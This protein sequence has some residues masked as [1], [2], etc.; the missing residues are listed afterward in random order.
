MNAVLTSTDWMPSGRLVNAYWTET[1]CEFLRLLRTPAL[2]IPF[3]IIPL[4]A[5]LMFGV[6]IASDAID[7]DPYVADYLF[8]GFSVMAVIGAALFGIG[9][10]LAVEREAG[11]LQLKRAMPAPAGVWVVAK[12]IVGLAFAALSYLPLPI[13]ALIVGQLTVSP[14]ELAAMSGAYLLGTLPFCALGMLIGALAS[15]SAAPAYA[16]MLYLPMLWLSG[17]FFP[18]PEFLHAQTLA[19]PAFH[20][21][22]IALHAGNVDKFI[23]VPLQLSLG[24]LAGL[25]VLCSAI[26]VWRLA[27]RG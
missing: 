5:Y 21:N 1:R 24:A 16:N 27:R 14:S 7:K 8:S 13:A 22:Q 11:L 10:T 20:L 17:M 3:L 25:T 2:V 18:L 9:C 4:A 12:M 15:A 19:W 23:Y 26:T 6:M